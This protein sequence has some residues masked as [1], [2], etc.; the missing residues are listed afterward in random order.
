MN[1][2]VLFS[3]C[4]AFF[5]SPDGNAQP[6]N[7]STFTGTITEAESEIPLKDAHIYHVER[8]AG[9]ISDAS[10]QFAIK[11]QAG[12][13]VRLVVSHVGYWTDTVDMVLS[14]GQSIDISLEPEISILPLIII[15]STRV[16]EEAPFTFENVERTELERRNWGTDIPMILE[17]SA[18]V[19]SSSDAGAGVGYTNMRIRGTDQTR[20]NVTI[21]GIPYNDPE[22]QGV[23]WVNLPDLTSS[24]SSIQIQRGVGT[25]TNGSGAFGATLNV[26]TT[27][28]RD[29]AYADVTLGA[30]SFATY[31]ATASF[32]TGWL[33]DRWSLSGRLSQIQSEGYIDR[34][35]SDLSSYYLS[36]R[37]KLPRTQLE[38]IQFSGDERTYQSWWGTPESR[39]NNDSAAMVEHAV[40]NG[41][42]SAQTANL[43]NS[44]RTYNY[45]TYENEVDQYGQDHYQLHLKSDLP[46]GIYSQAALHYTRG[47]GYFEQY[48]ADEDFADY[49]LPYPIYGSDTIK[50][51]DLIRRRWL[52]NHFYG[53][54]V[55]L[56]AT[57]NQLNFILGGAW[58]RYLGDH[59]GTIIWMDAA[60]TTQLNDRY[61]EGSSEKTDFNSYLKTTYN[62]DRWMW[63][64][65]LQYRQVNYFA[66]GID[67]DQKEYL[68]DRDFHF[69]NPKLGATLRL[70]AYENIY[71]SHA[72][73]HREPVR[74]DFIDAPAGQEP[75]PEALY[76]T[77]AGYRW[78]TPITQF[79][80]NVYHMYYR[81]QLVVTG[82]LN[83]VGA[84]VRT[85]IDRSYRA[86]VELSWKRSL[87]R[88]GRWDLSANLNASRNRIEHF[89]EVLYDYT[90][91]F[92]IIEN[93]YEN[94]PIALSP[95]VLGN[96]SIGYRWPMGF[97]ATLLGRFAGKQYLD[98]T[99]NDLRSIPA[100]GVMDA[101]VRFAQAT[102]GSSKWSL[103]LRV[104]NLLSSLYSTSGYTYSYIYGAT[105]TENFFYPQAERNFMV[106]L[107]VKF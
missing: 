4:C 46:Y 49:A 31:R 33:N 107:N 19:L 70:S 45:Y 32:G 41:L 18:S 86:G 85:N 98:N 9:V 79:S 7:A 67:N 3:L 58:N 54:T 94:T 91:G 105:I 43:L 69:I 72:I 57:R 75:R 64:A 2:L 78:N 106:Q 6:K 56:V 17:Q 38:Y 13:S 76:N 92:D 15:R 63:F 87:G 55:S 34:A 90:Q 51:T 14:L 66:Q 65:D 40:N 93:T 97:S 26:E 12:D 21:N 103:S 28:Q 11:G 39:I 62:S 77:E 47:L 35:S 71:L 23:F 20:I 22:S 99:G 27:E 36:A 73:A 80:V 24:A 74:S 52:D 96:A 81:D 84:N 95:D 25:S 50:N 102:S 29:S 10:G 83:D 104:N 44:G 101:M 88:D 82:E 53:A 48:R 37:Y 100:F 60:G 68:I 1:R 8:G 89:T 59:Y 30:G 61:Y 16:S 5:I 42:D